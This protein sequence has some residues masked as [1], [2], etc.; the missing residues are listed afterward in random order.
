MAIKVLMGFSG[1]VDSS[2]A[3]YL[4][5]RQGYDV[6]GC[7]MRNWDSIANNDIKGN[8]TLGGSKCSQE[9]DYDYAVKAASVLGIPLLRKDFID[10]YWDKVFEAFIDGLKKGLTPNPDVFCNRFVKFGSFLRFAKDKGFDMIAMGHYA[11]RVEVDGKACLAIP[12]DHEKDQT[13]FLCL[14]TKEQ[15]ASCL[16]P[17]YDMTKVEVRKVA[18]ELGLPNANKHG[19][20]GVCFIGE[21]NFRPFLE[22]YISP[23]KGDI[24][25][26]LSGKKV[27]E[28]EGAYF[29]AIGQHKGLNIGGRQGFAD[30]PFFV[31][32]KDVTDNVV[33]VAQQEGNEWRF[34][35]GCTLSH[36]NWIGPR[37]F[38]EVGD[39]LCKFR[40]RSKALPVRLTI[41]PDGS[42]ARLSYEG[43]E[44]IAPGQIAC[45]YDANGICL[46]GG[47]IE[48]TFGKDG[49]NTFE[50]VSK[51]IG[52]EMKNE[53]E[54]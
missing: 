53:K 23:R 46:G 35:Y 22:N 36:F 29:Y 16:F 14:T 3:A 8:P 44:Y 10:V 40:Y 52:K 6:T 31:V 9:I 26:L 39:C 24:I 13:Y 50:A 54:A 2:V 34:S 48:D 28:H 32:A 12:K 25:D 42:Q 30:E 18:G 37:P 1:G 15:I 43:Y 38:S 17:L 27:G 33:Y 51:A 19:S 49:V 45:L 7:F 11:K 21:R 4:L 47:V 5:K 20:T 41:A